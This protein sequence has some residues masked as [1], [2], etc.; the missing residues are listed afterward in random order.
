MNTVIRLLTAILLCV[1]LTGAPLGGLV[2]TA[3]PGPAVAD[4]GATPPIAWT[5]L[6]RSDQLEILGSNEA[7][8][9]DIPVPQGVTPGTLRGTVSSVVNVV[10]GRV[11]VIDGL[12][13]VLGSIPLPPDRVSAPFTV[14]ISGAEVNGGIAKLGFVIRDHSPPQNSC[15]QPPSLTLSE[16]A[17]TYV[18]RTPPPGIVADF[19][20]GY[21]ERFVIRTGPAPSPAAQQA[22]L[23]LVARLTRHYRPVPVRI[24]V[25]T[26][27]DPTPT[28][29]SAQRV[30]ELRDNGPAGMT[31][32]NPHSPRAALVIAGHGDELVRQI[33]LFADRRFKLAQNLSATVNSATS[34]A[35]Q[36]STV[37]TFAQ[38]GITGQTS[39]LGAAT[40]YVGVDVSQFA[41]GSVQQATL[42]LVGHYTP[43]LGGEASVVV[44]S[45]SAVLAAHRLDESGLLDIT[46]TIPAESIQ[47]NVGVALA[48]RYLPNQ[49][50]VPL[51]N[52]IQFTLD[53]ASTLSVTPGTYNRGGFPALPMAFTPG[54]DVV[55][56]QPDHLR[57]A[58]A[59][60]N[61]MA[62]Q[63]AVTLQPHITTMAAGAASGRG[64]LVVA[65]GEDLTR[66][67]FTPSV[68]AR[69][70]TT[71]GIGGTP[72]TDV[73]L[74]GPIGVIQVFTQS[75]RKV[76]AINGTQSWSL[77]DRS[78][79]HIRTLPSR[80][81]SLSGDVVATGSA[82][83]TVNLT[84]HEGGALIDEFPGDS[85]KRWAQVTA[86]VAAA[87]L[88]GAVGVLL[89]RR[90]RARRG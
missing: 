75:K 24:D 20:P 34:D 43:V 22:T 69:E 15:S 66:A 21:L 84:L 60:V 9:T 40:L 12:G 53:P 27:S 78:F 38:L 1:T 31:V 83:Q 18:G 25:D 74:H 61:L 46:E 2:A 76:L 14:D 32:T 86:V 62:Q 56:D 79:D 30:I 11:D 90:R 29:T 58:A 4:A 13:V 68:S 8:D 7:F 81:A 44:R 10:D 57:F 51:N 89:W 52:R 59:A 35:P 36:S 73:D 88:L 42:H 48:L 87:V 26:S 39:V 63:T 28:A 37:K 64:L 80:W 54:F 3:A 70:G 23:E 19:L 71:V 82:G 55:V 45:G 49:P 50:C 67:G 17:A 33:A 5:Q 47:S 41:A 85:W 6:G 72:N 65:S 16:L 77:V